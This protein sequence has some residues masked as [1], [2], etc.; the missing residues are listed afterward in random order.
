MYEQCR[1]MVIN[2]TIRCWDGKQHLVRCVHGSK[3]TRRCT[4]ADQ[5]GIEEC[6]PVFG[7]ESTLK[8]KYGVQIVYWRL[9]NAM[10]KYMK[11]LITHARWLLLTKNVLLVF[12]FHSLPVRAGSTG[13]KLGYFRLNNNP[14]NE[15]GN[16]RIYSRVDTALTSL[17]G[18]GTKLQSVDKIGML[19]K[20]LH[21]LSIP[22][23]GTTMYGSR[24]VRGQGMYYGIRWRV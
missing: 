13:N 23:I 8:I 11:R 2:H 19:R 18:L 22:C 14:I 17:R 3:S 1:R 16:N 20:I 9:L 6:I 15:I 10:Y 12:T 5:S 4:G 24:S 21:R 7:E